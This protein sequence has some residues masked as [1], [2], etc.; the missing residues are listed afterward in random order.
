ML[1]SKITPQRRRNRV[2]CKPAKWGKSYVEIE[3]QEHYQGTPSG[4]FPH[5][6]GHMGSQA[7]SRIS[8]ARSEQCPP[9]L[10][11]CEN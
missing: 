6:A 10:I 8:N 11:M 3:H 4:Q 5:S 1:H 7:A 9:L 2:V